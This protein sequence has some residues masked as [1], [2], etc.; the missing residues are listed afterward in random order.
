VFLKLSKLIKEVKLNIK[1]GTLVPPNCRELQEWQR[2]G[3]NSDFER[4]NVVS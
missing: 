3:A 4:K 2:K 1:K